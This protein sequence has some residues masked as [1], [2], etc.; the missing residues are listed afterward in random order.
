[1]DVG[2]PS[3]QLLSRRARGTEGRKAFWSLRDLV[4]I[5]NVLGKLRREEGRRGWRGWASP[6]VQNVMCR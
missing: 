1:M 5:K 2:S 3:S 4:G 6:L